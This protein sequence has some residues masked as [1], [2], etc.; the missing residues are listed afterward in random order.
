MARSAIAAVFAAIVVVA[1]AVV[2]W[3]AVSSR[4]GDDESSPVPAMRAVA[5]AI[6]DGTGLVAAARSGGEEMQAA[7]DAFLVP[8]APTEVVAEVLDL[9]VDDAEATATLRVT[10][11]TEVVGEI[12]WDATIAASRRRGNWG[13]DG[14]ATTI[15]PDMRPGRL[16]EVVRTDVTRAPIL[17]HDG[18]ALTS[19][20]S[21]QVIG[22]APGRVVNDE[23]LRTTWASTLPGS[24]QDLIDLLERTDTNPEWFYPVV[25]VSQATYEDVWPRLRSIP[26]VLA[27]E[28]SDETPT[29]E[30]FARHV[31]GR[32]GEPTAELADELGVDPT[33]IVGL[34]GL[35]RVFEERLVGSSEVR[36]LITQSDGDEVSVL[37]TSEDDSAG[38][39]ETTLDRTVQQAVENALEGVE[40]PAA[41]VMVD[42][43][44]GGIRASASRPL[45]GYN[46]AWEGQYPPGDAFALVAAEAVLG[47]GVD[48]DDPA[49]CPNREAVAGALLTARLTLEE[50]TVGH[51]LA[52]GCDTTL[53]MLVADLESGEL[54]AAAGR[55]GFGEEPDL[56]L[57]ATGGSFPAPI[58]RTEQVR[59]GVGQ[60]RVL[61]SPLHL[62]SVA[63]AAAT[64]TWRPPFLLPDDDRP[65]PRDLT[66]AAAGDLRVLLDLATEDTGAGTALGAVGGRG[67][68][69]SAP[70][71]GGDD[72]HAWAVVVGDGVAGVVLVEDTAGAT[73]LAE[74]IA[75]RFLRELDALSAAAA[76]G[77]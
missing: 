39:L 36:V 7:L 66:P 23:R 24:L 37:A 40:V 4:T 16:V 45:G 11:T 19:H 1:A 33:T 57:P 68:V 25:T 14:G 27:R 46:R 53:G 44:D 17:A 72:A 43:A 55:F 12:T 42:L 26:G 52:A 73:E 35:E 8:L 6:E 13:V 67:Y 31:L 74:S 3:Q 63:A 5:D 30:S 59:A 21:S 38:P 61:A 76:D 47:T 22:I 48:L 34:Y 69:G 49:T 32:V 51:A 62:A 18:T 58:D 64:G 2:G 60:G 65:G 15:H 20:G 41:V 75:V 9:D 77:A 29:G 28:S 71:T 54:D 70:V 10:L 56:V 50:T